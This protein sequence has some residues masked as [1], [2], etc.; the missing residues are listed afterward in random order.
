M[1]RRTLSYASAAAAV[2]IAFGI[3]A[4]YLSRQPAPEGILEG[5]GQVRGTEVTVS[6]RVGGIAQAVA[7]REGQTIKRG[8]LVARIDAREI[9]A[10]LAQ[11][12]AEVEALKAKRAEAQ[13]QVAAI[14]T[15][16]GQ[17]VIG[18]Q[19]SRES[20]EHE[21]H[22]ARAALERAQAEV[23]AAEAEA[24]QA[25]QLE[26]R[27]AQLA[28]LQFVSDSYQEGVRAQAR[29]SEARVS[30]ARRAREEAT[31]ALERARAAA[32]GVQIKAQ[33]ATRLAAE[34][35]RIQASSEALARTEDAARARVA[36]VEATLADTRIVAPLDATVMN[37][38]AEPGELIAP[39]RPMATLIDLG[40]LFVRVYIPGR[41]IA[42]IRLGNP[43]RVYAD[44][45]PGR[46]FDGTVVEVAERAEFTPKD[47]HVKDEREKMVYGVKVALENPEGYLKPGMPVDVQ[48]KWQ[49]QAGWPPSQ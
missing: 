49:E 19:V 39:G 24:R 36:E 38:L 1:K 37:R 40:A 9:E 30:A 25:D 7:V 41:D 33:D 18:A 48:V 17:A 43:A 8:A 14:T 31:A 47:A 35:R 4:V 26:A 32:G 2:A 6:A 46:A 3:S 10:Q 29:A 42:K 22:G 16:I 11:A 21:I 15:A 13:A 28:R 44:A 5:S 20:S 23:R 12:R 34:R 45:F 27:Y